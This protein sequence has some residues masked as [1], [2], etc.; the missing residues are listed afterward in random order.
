VKV[1]QSLFAASFLLMALA[2]C[3]ADTG[4]EYKASTIL[5]GKVT[6]GG[7]PLV[8]DKSKMG[9]YARVEATFIPQAGGTP[10]TVVVQPD[11]TFDMVTTEGKPLPAGKYKVA[12][13]QW[14]P[15]NSNDLLQ[16]KFDE[17]NTPIVR[18][19][20]ADTK[21]VTIDLDNPNG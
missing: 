7:Q 17:K 19:I 13:R 21:E 16:G 5:K 15:V 11:G 4:P 14:Q 8:V 1:L 6:K 12:V 10:H 9:D 20:T 3:G 2:G 18:D